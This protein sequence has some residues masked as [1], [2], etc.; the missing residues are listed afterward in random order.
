[1]RRTKGPIDPVDFAA[2]WDNY[3][4]GCGRLLE[5]VCPGQ[6]AEGDALKAVI[7]GYLVKK[8]SATGASKHILALYDHL[9]RHA[10][11]APLFDRYASEAIDPTAPCLPANASFAARLAHASDVYSLVPAQRDALSH[12]LAAREG[13]ILAVNGPPGTGKTTLL[14]SVV[15][16]L[17]AKA[18]IEGDEPPV[19]LAASANNQAVTNIIDAFGQDFATGTGPLAC[20]WLPHVKSFGAYFPSI[21]REGEAAGQYQTRSFFEGVESENYVA[22][23]KEHY[24]QRRG[25]VPRARTARG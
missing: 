8:A 13:E 2:R 23:A 25:G 3:L 7:Y 6:L 4:K 19:I 9:R 12:L 15:A 17:W 22:T 10:P 21:A 5:E 18:A 20:R 11:S 14:L 1:M 24:L 16:S